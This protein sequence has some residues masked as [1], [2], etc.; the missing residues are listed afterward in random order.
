MPAAP[1]SGQETPHGADTTVVQDAVAGMAV[2]RPILSPLDTLSLTDLF[3]V[4]SDDEITRELAAARSEERYFAQ[5]A[6]TAKQD[7]KRAG[8]Q[9][10]IAKRDVDALKPR[11]ELAKQEGQSGEQASFAEKKKQMEANVRLL[12][13]SR[14]LIDAERKLYEAQRD[15]ARARANAAEVEQR[16]ADSRR[17]ITE[18]G[19]HPLANRDYSKAVDRFLDL[20]K[21]TARIGKV[22]ATNEESVADRRQNAFEAQSAWLTTLTGVSLK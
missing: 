5:G 13:R 11:I 16:L 21:T 8:V 12:E 14:D 18:L 20:Q 10:K 2:A 7:H 4:R 17:R 9:I 1:V 6:A 3:V 22:V 19:Q 15:H